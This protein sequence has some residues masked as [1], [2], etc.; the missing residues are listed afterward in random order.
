MFLYMLVK[1]IKDNLTLFNNTD[2]DKLI[3]RK[4]REAIFKR[5]ETSPIIN[6]DVGREHSKI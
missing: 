3:S 5:K 6:R 1:D 4:V 2:E